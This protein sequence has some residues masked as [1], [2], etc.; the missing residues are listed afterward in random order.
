MV[1]NFLQQV[2]HQNHLFKEKEAICQI[3]VSLGNLKLIIF[4]PYL[5]TTKK[6][7]GNDMTLLSEHVLI[8]RCLKICTYKLCVVRCTL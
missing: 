5:T 6:K 7:F 3:E 8:I 2:W 1:N 4:A